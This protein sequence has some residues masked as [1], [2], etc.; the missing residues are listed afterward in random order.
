[1]WLTGMLDILI[2]FFFPRE[3]RNLDFISN[4]LI[5]KKNTKP[6]CVCQKE[7]PGWPQL[8]VIILWPLFCDF[9]LKIFCPS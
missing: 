3:A 6:H 9:H 5:K 7:L 4:V 1:M 2:F 8:A